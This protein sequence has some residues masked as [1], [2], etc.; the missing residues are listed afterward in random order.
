MDQIEQIIFFNDT[1]STQKQSYDSPNIGGELEELMTLG[2][3]DFY[4]KLNH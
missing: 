3:S 2:Y 1:P 4:E